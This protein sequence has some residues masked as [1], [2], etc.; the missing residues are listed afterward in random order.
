[1]NSENA[2]L[3]RDVRPSLVWIAGLLLQLWI[4]P[5]FAAE[6]VKRGHQTVEDALKDIKPAGW[7]CPKD[8]APIAT[9]APVAS[10]QIA[11][12]LSCAMMP[13][14]AGAL[15]GRPDTFV[16]DT[17]TAKDFMG[18]HI[19]G[20][21]NLS[22]TEVRVKAFLKNKLILLAGDGRNE[23]EQ[24]R[25]CAELKGAGF[26]RVKVVRGGMPA[27]LTQHQ[28]V[29]GR[30][31]APES[32][33]RLT[34]T[35][36]WSETRFDSNAVF[37]T[38]AMSSMQKDFPKAILLKDETPATF[39]AAIDKLKAGGSKSSVLGATGALIYVT[40]KSYSDEKIARL[41]QQS[42]PLPVLVYADT[43]ES[44]RQYVNAQE[45]VWKAH[46]RG[47]KQPKCGA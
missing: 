24:Y 32:L 28:P 14:E 30:V 27:W 44:F 43:P 15:L 3:I 45:A 16:V 25:A 10:N 17:R 2:H 5:A 9:G 23:R 18:F 39:K 35:Q 13:K 11:P 12:D 47:P 29:I 26:N 4:G 1:M 33:V 8:D 20:A 38:P 6:P 34:Q 40:G 42:A 21:M 19:D 7:S 46:A 31:E 22:A 41:I 37:L 36:L